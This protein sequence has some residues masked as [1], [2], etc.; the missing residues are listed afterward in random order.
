[1]KRGCSTLKKSGTLKRKSKKMNDPKYLADRKVETQKMWEL[2]EQHWNSKKHVCQVCGEGIFGENKN[3]YHHHCWPKASYPEYKYMIEG[4]LLVCW[5]CH[6]NIEN[7]YYT[8]ET[9]E[10]L[11]S[12]KQ[13]VLELL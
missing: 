9:K 3:L 4:L 6:S 13:K 10:M 11:E 12:I 7:C 8:Q 2:F 1:M 5:Q